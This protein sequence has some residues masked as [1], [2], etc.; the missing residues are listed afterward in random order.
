MKYQFTITRQHLAITKYLLSATMVHCRCGKCGD[1]II[2]QQ[3]GVAEHCLGR[4]LPS[5]I[6][7]RV[8]KDLINGS[9]Y[10]E[11]P[12]QRAG[13]AHLEDKERMR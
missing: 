1:C 5:D 12:S 8:Y 10:A 4:V 9:Y 7:R 11:S 6:G 13:R 3:A 2:V